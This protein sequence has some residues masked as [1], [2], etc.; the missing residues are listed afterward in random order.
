MT[1]RLDDL[2]AFV[3]VVRARGFREAARIENVS[4]SSMSEAVKRLETKLAVRL[5]H[6]T[7]RSISPTEAGERLMSRV[8]PAL[9]EIGSVLDAL[10]TEDSRTTGTLRLNV[11]A[12]V[13]LTVLPAIV[14]RFLRAHP[15]IRLEVTAED[16]FVDILA[17]RAD[18]G[19]RYEERLEQ[20]MIAIPI[21]PRTQRFVTAASPAYLETRGTPRRPEDLLCHDCMRLRFSSRAPAIW[22]FERGEEIVRIEP[23]GPLLVQPGLASDLL[24]AASVAGLGVVRLFHDWLKPQ[25]ERGEL[26]PILEDWEEDFSGP[27]LYYAGR[28]HLPGPLRAF[29]DF[30]RAQ[31]AAWDAGDANR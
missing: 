21:G 10:D 20:D 15:G 6:R 31:P 29:I 22:E 12:N 1:G 19:I 3:A 26:V 13:M 11:P 18:A 27:M 28:R 17:A 14:P 5:L 2:S 9:E 30:I 16:S 7:T 25:L 8:G 23:K 24:I 4:P